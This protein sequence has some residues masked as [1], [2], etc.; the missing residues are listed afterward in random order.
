MSISL[1]SRQVGDPEGSGSRRGEIQRLEASWRGSEAEAAAA[2]AAC[3][4]QAAEARAL[5]ALCAEQRDEGV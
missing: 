5:Q 2:E 1:R 4:A 3:A